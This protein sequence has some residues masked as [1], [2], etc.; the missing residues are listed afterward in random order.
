MHTGMRRSALAFF[1]LVILL[2]QATAQQQNPQPGEIIINLHWITDSNGCKV[3]NSNPT[4]NESVTWSGPCSDGYADGSGTLTW[5]ANG[6]VHSTYTG[7]MHSGH[8][9]G[10][11]TQVWPTG[12]RYEGEWKN[13]RADG[14]GIY[15]PSQGAGCSGIWVD[16]CLVGCPISIGTRTCP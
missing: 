16:G 7:E 13:D 11:G 8:Y 3:W 9:H 2:D 15:W 5:F 6:A 10:R 12:A 4:G 14:P 1:F